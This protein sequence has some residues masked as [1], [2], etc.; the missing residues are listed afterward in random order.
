MTGKIKKINYDKGYGFIRKD[1]SGGGDLFFHHTACQ[2]GMFK[3]LTEGQTVSFEEEEAPDGRMR[4][5]NV[6]S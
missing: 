4:A 1:E 3:A 5:I 6:T 2:R